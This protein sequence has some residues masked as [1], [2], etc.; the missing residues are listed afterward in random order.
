MKLKYVIFDK[1]YPLVFGEYAQHK[2]VRI[3]GMRPTSAGFLYLKEI[4]TPPGSNFCQVRIL[5]AECYGESISLNL[6]AQPGD[7]EIIDKMF[8]V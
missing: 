2:D 4:E 8:N 6:K 5:K 3:N 1:F 7:S